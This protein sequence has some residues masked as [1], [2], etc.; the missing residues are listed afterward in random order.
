MSLIDDLPPEWFD[1][2]V[3]EG[4]F[5]RHRHPGCSDGKDRALGVVKTPWGWYVSCFRCK[6]RGF[7]PAADLPPDQML[8]W[9]LVKEDKENEEVP[10]IKLPGDFTKR[11]PAEG[12]AWLYSCGITDADREEH[13]IG[14]SP[15]RNRVILPIYEGA[16]LVYW[17]GRYLGEPDAQHPK[18]SNQYRAGRREVWFK[19]LDKHTDHV[20]VVEDILSCIVVGKVCDSY[21]LLHATVPDR[22]VF[23]LCKEY[24]RVLLWLDPD[25]HTSMDQWCVRYQSFGLKVFSIKT[26]RD[27]KYYDREEIL[28]EVSVFDVR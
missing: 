22:L 17:Q 4:E 6:Q 23:K 28:N 18:Y 10:V 11:I 15:H 9:Q 13:H 8:E 16:D 21:A 20:V 1:V 12:L 14:F 7:K 24:K 5:K 3:R 26:D 27:P 25:K 2:K 19:V